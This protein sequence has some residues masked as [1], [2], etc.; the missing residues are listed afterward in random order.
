MAQM[1]TVS[2]TLGLISRGF[3]NERVTPAQVNSAG[4]TL[5]TCAR[6]TRHLEDRLFAMGAMEQA[7]CF[8]CGYS[9]AGYFQADMHSCAKRHH[10]AK[11]DS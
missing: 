6:R 9:G 4:T 10:A 2:D 11:Q 1:M 8:C 5:K 3:L 7:P